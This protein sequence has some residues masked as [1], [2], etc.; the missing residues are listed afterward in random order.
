V[1]HGLLLERRGQRRAVAGGK[2]ASRV[3]RYCADGFVPSAL[4]FP[5]PRGAALK[6]LFGR[7]QRRARR[8][9]IAGQRRKPRLG[10]NRCR[11][12]PRAGIVT[13]GGEPSGKPLFIGRSQPNQ[14][15]LEA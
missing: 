13:T 14:V 4:E 12:R 10:R 6:S 8:R 9:G 7:R 11:A 3:D 1:E 15:G 2:A 5:D